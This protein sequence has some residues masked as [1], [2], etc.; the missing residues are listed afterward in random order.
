[1]PRKSKRAEI[2]RAAYAIVAG[3]GGIEA[4]T[5]DR[6]AAE[7]DLSKSGLLYHFPSRHELL[8][9]LHE[10][11][12]GLWEDKVRARAGGDAADLA[13]RERYRAM[14]VTMSEHEPLAELLV[15]LHA[16][17]HPD[18][19]R[20][21]LEVEDRWLP[22]PDD[23]ATDPDLLA[24]SVLASGLWVHDHI[25]ARPLAEGNRAVIVEKLLQLL[26]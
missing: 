13:P 14:L 7:T 18:Y 24:A 2:L 26:N 4:V 9:G 25:Y 21:W 1:M 8:V 5:Y 12:A 22:R 19:T 10:Y 3:P 16:H 11:T 20:P 15:T 17:T 23:T 6:L